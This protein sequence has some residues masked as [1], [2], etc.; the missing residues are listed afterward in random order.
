MSKFLMRMGTKKE[1]F[2]VLMKILSVEIPVKET[3]NKMSIEWRRG[4]KKSETKTAFEL[5]REKPIAY[6][7]ETF[8][9]A[10]IFYK[11]TKTEKYFKKL[12]HIRVKGYTASG[13]SKEK[14]L[15][16]L[17]L[18]IS[19]FMNSAGDT[20]ILQLNKALPNSK[21][22][23]QISIQKDDGNSLLQAQANNIQGNNFIDD[24][25]S[26]DESSNSINLMGGS[27]RQTATSDQSKFEEL[28]GREI[29]QSIAMTA[30]AMIDQMGTSHD[31]IYDSDRTYTQ[32]LQIQDIEVLLKDN[33]AQRWRIKDLEKDIE[34]LKNQ[35]EFK[36]KSYDNYKSIMEQKLDELE[37]EKT[38]LLKSLRSKAESDQ[39]PQLQ[40]QIQQE[41]EIQELKKLIKHLE[42]QN[43]NT[44]KTVNSNNSAALDT[45]AQELKQTI[46]EK[47]IENGKLK[48]ELDEVKLEITAKNT[49]NAIL[50]EEIQKLKQ[51]LDHLPQ[52]KDDFYDIDRFS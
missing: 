48:Q 27:F 30:A 20:K 13:G 7:N 1:R 26:E 47:E 16:E 22:E 39:N 2:L 51:E 52:V 24:S 40:S 28:K 21:I 36:Q 3:V 6:V 31:S 12:A 45:L 17:E 50:K 23:L 15:G 32:T 43:K 11:S 44:L 42:E 33:E 37:Q 41:L 46:Q 19:L 5:T 35:I 29:S 14:I 4:N 34:D 49:D 10:S 9:K 18:D 25:S 8:S 38:D